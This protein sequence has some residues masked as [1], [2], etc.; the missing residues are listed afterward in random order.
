MRL[1]VKKAAP[2]PEPAPSSRKTP[3]EAARPDIDDAE[4]RPHR[5]RDEEEE[6]EEEKEERRGR[7]P[8][9]HR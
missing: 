3:V 8:R 5:A 1:P 7:P 4:I 9:R 6:D 2:E